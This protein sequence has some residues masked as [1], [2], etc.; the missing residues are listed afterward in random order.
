MYHAFDSGKTR[1]L[2]GI[3]A[4]AEITKRWPRNSATLMLIS[5]GDTV[6]PTGMRPLP[7]SIGGVLVIG[8]GDP[9][10]G[11]FIDGRNSRQDASALRQIATRLNGQYHDANAKL[12]PTS[13]LS[14]VGSLRTTDPTNRFGRREWALIATALSTLTLSLLPRLLKHFGTRFRPGPPITPGPKHA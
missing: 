13:T 10:K 6:P 9:L 4:A 3:A 1:L 12:V 2:D 14:S 7:P 8:V 5:D 11:T